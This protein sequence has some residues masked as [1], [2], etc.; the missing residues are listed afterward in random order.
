M[1]YL[2]TIFFSLIIV[3]YVG[4]GGFWEGKAGDNTGWFPQH[5]IIEKT[6]GKHCCSNDYIILV[7]V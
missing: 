3:L 7:L 1:I 5:A 4:K 2:L 6:D